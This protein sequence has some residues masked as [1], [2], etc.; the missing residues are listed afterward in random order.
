MV[1]GM[2]HIPDQRRD[3]TVALGLLVF[4]VSYCLFV[5]LFGVFGLV[6]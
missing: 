2:Q 1:I 5:A 4:V 6:F 3:L